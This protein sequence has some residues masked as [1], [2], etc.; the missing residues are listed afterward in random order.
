MGEN[1]KQQSYIVPRGG[2]SVFDSCLL[3]YASLKLQRAEGISNL[4]VMDRIVLP[5]IH[6]L[7]L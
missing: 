3:V 2:I 6:M 7:K 5:K 4:V 1:Y